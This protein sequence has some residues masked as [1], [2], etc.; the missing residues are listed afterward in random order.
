MFLHVP[1]VS[2]KNYYY[3]EKLCIKKKHYFRAGHMAQQAL[4]FKPD[5]LKFA[6]EDPHGRRKK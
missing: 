3:C 5:G 4:V 2:L 1:Y 6:P